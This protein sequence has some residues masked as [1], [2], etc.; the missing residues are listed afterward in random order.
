[1]TDACACEWHMTDD[2]LRAVLDGFVAAVRA[3]DEVEVA[4]R[5]LMVAPCWTNV[6]MLATGLAT[7]AGELVRDAAACRHRNHKVFAR[8]DV[9]DGAPD[10]V[11]HAGRMLAVATNGDTE[12]LSALVDVLVSRAAH[13]PDVDEVRLI[14]GMVIADLVQALHTAVRQ[15]DLVGGGC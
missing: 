10:H 13:G 2:D 1:M 11:V 12:T 6:A 5:G 4:C 8:L 14:A 9:P 3:G 15:H 7:A